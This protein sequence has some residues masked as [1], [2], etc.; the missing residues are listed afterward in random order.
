MKT[1]KEM[2]DFIE[3]LI[4]SSGEDIEVARITKNVLEIKSNE[5]KFRLEI[6]PARLP[7]S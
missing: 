1:A 3:K 2:I 6:G 7:R 5:K 4:S